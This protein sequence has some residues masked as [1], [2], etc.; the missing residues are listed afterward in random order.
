MRWKIILPN[1]IIVL[2][3]GVAGWIYLQGY[4]TDVF[5]ERAERA[6]ERDRNLFVA[7]N[8]LRAV[9]FLRT[10]MARARNSEVEAVFDPVTEEEL[11]EI[12]ESAEEEGEATDDDLRLLLRRRAHIE[13]QAFRTFLGRDQAGS[14]TP[15]LVAITDRNGLVISRDVDP[16]AEPVGLNLAEQYNSVQRAL[17][18]NA[19]RDIWYWNNFLLDV[20]LAPI[21]NRG[22]VE[23]V[24]LVGYDISN[25]VAQADREMFGFEV[26]YLLQEEVQE[27]QRWNLHSASIA[28]GRGRNAL[29]QQIDSQQARLVESINSREPVF[30]H[31]DIAG[32]PHIGLGGILSSTGASVPAG[33]LLM[34]SVKDVRAP[35]Q[36][37]ILVFF[38]ALGG[39]VLVVA[40]GFFLGWH[41]LTPIEQ[42][43]EGVLRVINGDLEHRFEVQS[44]EFG[45]LA[46]RV[47]Q[48]VAELT[49]EEESEEEE[50]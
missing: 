3:V 40:V 35:A 21:Q 10:V 7:A 32:E 4:Y 33:Y 14:R 27:E 13:C 34:A 44:S 11:A 30:L 8:Q 46:Y 18:G 23:G 45:G 48:L 41:F 5:D 22:N 36:E 17:Q 49:G 37:A 43:E 38:F 42:I 31:F 15:E 50:P 28:A 2:A 29:R 1:L 47:N 24:L 12:R 26:A 39:L 6:L 9:K 25:G 19:V 20:A 16:N